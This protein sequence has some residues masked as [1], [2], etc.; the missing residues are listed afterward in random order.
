MYPPWAADL[1][2]EGCSRLQ[3]VAAAQAVFLLQNA[4]QLQLFLLQEVWPEGHALPYLGR[5]GALG[6]FVAGALP[7]CRED[8]C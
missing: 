6:N 5:H 3:E 7:H 4:S 1:C 2:F 8:I